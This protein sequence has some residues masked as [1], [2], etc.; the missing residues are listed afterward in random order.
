MIPFYHFGKVCFLIWLFNP[1]TLGAAKL[2][3]GILKPF[4][5]KHEGKIDKVFKEV[6]KMS[7]E[8]NSKKDE[9]YEESK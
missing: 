2:Y 6:D 9:K 1:A 5:K 4:I 8:L 3:N 7:K